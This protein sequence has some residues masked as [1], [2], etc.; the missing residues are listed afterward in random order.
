MTLYVEGWSAE[1]EQRLMEGM[2]VFRFG[3][4]EWEMELILT[5]REISHYVGTKSEQHCVHHYTQAYLSNES[6]IPDP[7]KVQVDTFP[8][9]LVDEPV[10]PLV[11][12]KKFI[13]GTQVPEVISMDTTLFE[14][15]MMWN[16][17]MM[18]K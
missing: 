1:E 15:T 10:P 14:M 5:S 12:W 2:Q 16:M 8:G 3:N 7:A 4:W 13:V 17:T 9:D 11:L 6:K 18:L